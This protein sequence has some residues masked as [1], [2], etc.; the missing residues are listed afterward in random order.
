[1]LNFAP[2]QQLTRNQTGFNG[3][4]D[5]HIISDQ[6][7]DGIEPERQQQ[8]HK[9]VRARLNG[10]ARKGTKRPGAGTKAQPHRVA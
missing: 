2:V 7:A 10:D 8:R 3:L 6:Q 4:A 1:M 5:A 9:L